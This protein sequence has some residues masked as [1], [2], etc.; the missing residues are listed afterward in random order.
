MREPI[1]EYVQDEETSVSGECVCRGDP[2]CFAFDADRN[3]PEHELFTPNVCAYTL[4]TDECGETGKWTVAAV[5]ERVKDVSST[6]S[7][8]KEVVIKYIDDVGKYV[9]IKL[10][11][12]LRVRFG[13]RDI[14]TFPN[15]IG[16]FYLDIV[17][18]V[19]AHPK[20]FSG[21][22][23]EVVSL[24]FPNGVNVQYDGVK[25]VKINMDEAVTGATCGLCGNNDG[26]Y[27]SRDLAQGYNVNGKICKGLYAP[28]PSMTAVGINYKERAVLRTIR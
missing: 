17:P 1:G 19:S 7:F 3:N 13:I 28:G 9:I 21:D 16:G 15:R 18:A 10:K 24:T 11:Q 4:A 2:H 25:V 23:A 14:A 26:V 5:F 6:R 20:D 12:G 27:D 8:V 22:S